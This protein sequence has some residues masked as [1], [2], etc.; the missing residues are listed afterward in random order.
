MKSDANARS[1]TITRYDLVAVSFHWVLA[2][3][4]PGMIALGW[5]M[6]S[7]EKQP[8]SPWYF[9]LHKSIGLV[10]I[11]LVLLRLLWRL[12]H[13]PPT[14]P[15]TV[16]GWQAT[17]AR[18]VQ[19][20][21]YAAMIVMPLVGLTGA[22]FSKGGIK[23]FGSAIPRLVAPDHGISETFFTAHSFIAWVLVVLISLHV[24]GGLKHLLIDKD[25]VFQR[26]WHW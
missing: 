11:A 26:M 14:L 8:G 9:N 10:I 19:W 18:W 25:G 4:I 12:T 20:L 21:L 24:L 6:M 1:P 15:S 16:P 5:Y 17:A 22:L 2:V 7:I 23:F 13:K 3:L